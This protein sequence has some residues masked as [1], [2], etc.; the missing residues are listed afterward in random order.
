VQ[1]TLRAIVEHRRVISEARAAELAGV[2]LV[3][4]VVCVAK[5]EVQGLS[6]L[7]NAVSVSA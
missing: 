3:H 5:V 1:D 6:T 2:S 4:F 7:A